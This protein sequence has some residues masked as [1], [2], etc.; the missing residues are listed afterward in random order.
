MLFDVVP[1]DFNTD[2]GFVGYGHTAVRV[3]GVEIVRLSIEEIGA[4]NEILAAW[5]YEPD[6]VVV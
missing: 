3:D 4:M 2:A 1:V 5:V 6:F